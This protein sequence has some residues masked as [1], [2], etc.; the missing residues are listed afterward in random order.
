MQVIIE[1]PQG[2]NKQKQIR[3]RTSSDLAWHGVQAFSEARPSRNYPRMLEKKT[4][5]TKGKRYYKHHEQLLSDP[6]GSSSW[7]NPII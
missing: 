1:F 3:C 7:S 4:A 5:K 2:S 6:S